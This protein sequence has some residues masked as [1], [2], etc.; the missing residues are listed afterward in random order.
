MKKGVPRM[1]DK[2]KPPPLKLIRE[3][4]DPHY[5]HGHT[6]APSEIKPLRIIAIAAWSILG[7]LILGF[8]GAIIIMT[9]YA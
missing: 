1:K 2:P 6:I 5:G 9:T 4:D 3:G 8:I 7:G